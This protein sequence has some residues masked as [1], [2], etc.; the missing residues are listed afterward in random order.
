MDRSAI[1]REERRRQVT[2]DLEFERDRAGQLR[3]E[4]NR[5]ALELE[6]PGIEEKV[7][8]K[9][10]AEDV[11]LI[12]VGVQDVEREG[13]QED[14]LGGEAPEEDQVDDEQLAA[15]LRVEQEAEIVRL[16][17]EIVVTERR[18]QALEAYLEALASL[19]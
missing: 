17:E 8:A 11:E 16:E 6:G 14:W 9:M 7:F 3:E 18:Q 13:V 19:G 15:E 1:A 12:H 2:E 10:Q 4:I 5:L